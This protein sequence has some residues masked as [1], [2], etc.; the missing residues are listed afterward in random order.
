VRPVAITKPFTAKKAG[1]VREAVAIPPASAN[2]PVSRAERLVQ[3]LVVLLGMGLV[4]ALA[5]RGEFAAKW[6]Y[7]TTTHW[8]SVYWA[9]A[10]IWGL[11]M[12]ALLVWRIVLWRRYKPM[13]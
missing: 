5:G 3:I 11:F 12:Y 8:G 9:S 1:P 10:Y 4:A 6:K 7:L 2:Q 13:V